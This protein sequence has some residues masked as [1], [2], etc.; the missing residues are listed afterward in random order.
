[1]TRTDLTEVVG[2]GFGIIE[3]A[4]PWQI[5]NG[6]AMSCALVGLLE[7]ASDEPRRARL[8]DQRTILQLLAVLDDRTDPI[9]K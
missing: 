3:R 2:G 1:V 5:S 9:G 6:F 8:V 7:I 4:K